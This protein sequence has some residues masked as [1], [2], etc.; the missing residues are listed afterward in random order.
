LRVRAEFARR[1]AGLI[2]AQ[3]NYDNPVAMDRAVAVNAALLAQARA[4]LLRLD[5][6][7]AQQEAILAELQASYDRLAQ[8]GEDSVSQLQVEQ[9]MYQ[10]QSQHAAVQAVGQQRPELEATVERYE[11]QLDAAQRD[12]EL[13]VELR[14]AVDESQAAADEA[15]VAVDEAQLRLDRMTIRSTVAGVVMTRMVSPG[16][17]VMLGMDG[18]HSAHVMH[19]YDPSSLQVRVDVP[20]ADAS[21]VGVGQRAKIII[22]ALPDVEFDGVVTRLVHQAD[23]SKNTVQ[24]KVEIHDPVALIKP[25]MLARVKF[26][27]TNQVGGGGAVSGGAHASVAIAQSAVVMDGNDAYVW[28][29]SPVDQRLSRQAVTLGGERSDGWV[30]VIQ[31]LNPGDV[32]VAQPSADLHE[33]QRV[34][35]RD[36]P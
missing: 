7:V 32:M 21:A 10:T 2:A 24:V 19:L 13:K 35:V 36:E 1:Q 9:A 5:A 15:R 31:G 6:Q 14:R 18:E 8:L 26:L 25:D 33:G 22:D 28:R 3:T 17:K 27:A 30:D 4:A 16:D 34:E 12:L 20:L 23:I 11:A 29:V